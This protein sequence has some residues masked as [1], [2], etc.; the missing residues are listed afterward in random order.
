MPIYEYHCPKCE[1]HFEVL[2]KMSDEPLAACPD[3]H[4][5][6]K[7]LVSQTSFA[8]K[9]G[10]WYKDGYTSSKGSGDAKKSTKKDS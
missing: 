3:C 9:G 5:Q 7:R 4:A 8:L 6:V 1:K 10:G 2:Q